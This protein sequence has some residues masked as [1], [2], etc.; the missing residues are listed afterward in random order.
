VQKDTTAFHHH[1]DTITKLS[2]RILECQRAYYRGSPLISDVEYDALE[3][4][5]QQL[6]PK[7][8]I[9]WKVGHKG[10]VDEGKKV[11]HEPPMLSLAKTY[12]LEELK[13]WAKGELLTGTL[14]VD[15]VSLSLVYENGLLVLAKTRGN[16]E[17]GEDV[18]K[19]IEWVP[20][21]LR[22]LVSI[23]PGGVIPQKA[24][25]RG[26]LYC[27][28]A[29]FS[30]LLI[31]ME[32]LALDKPTSP[33]NIVAGILGRKHHD[34]LARYFGFF[35]FDLLV[36]FQEIPFKSEVEKY[37]WLEDHRFKLPFYKA[38]KTEAQIASFL[39]ETK[40][41][42]EEGELGI[43]GAVFT[44]D[45]LSKHEELGKTSHHPRYKLSYKWQGETKESQIKDI[46]WA[47]SRLGIVTPVAIVDP[48][49]LSSAS[50]TNVTLHNAAYVKQ[51]NLKTGDVIK[52]VRSGEVIPKFLEVVEAASGEAL[53]PE[54]CP[55]CGE[56]LYYDQVR[57]LCS[58]KKS[59]PAQQFGSILNWI[60]CAEIDDLSEKRVRSMVEL[61][62][63][64]HPSDLYRLSL[65]DLLKLP[66]TK[67]KMAQKL[68]TNI[69]K[70]KMLPLTQFLNGLGV[71]G[72]GRALWEEV[73]QVFPSLE[74]ILQ[75]KLEDIAAISGFGTLRATV[76][77]E[78]LQEK[79]P[80]IQKLLEVGV[81]PFIRVKPVQQGS[82]PLAGKLFV[83]TGSLSRPRQEVVDA[84]VLAG[85]K[86]TESVSKK[87]TALITEALDSG[88]SKAKKAQ[89]LTIPIWSEKELWDKTKG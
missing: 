26:E 74:K 87:V 3:K 44:Y 82:L 5:L 52:I 36:S 9:L 24:E 35:A 20:D 47:T 34:A 57:L 79:T 43:D 1:K 75:A 6:D 32:A 54:N 89:E 15:G 19:K 48:V 68:L 50:I 77:V 51:F 21:C 86:V 66:L 31:E 63:I 70:S 27:D 4:Q 78:A 60:R 23:K 71:P 2:E 46:R 28:D 18:T 84:I 42:M 22:K 41:F 10:S 53:L 38:L 55:S 49:Y 25:I 16:G 83:I 33:R 30:K 59:C 72:M 8:P 62:L 67:E 73:L 80:D 69:A 85:G 58:Q 37:H 13:T 11:A 81:E 64:S 39:E 61:G 14:K 40:Y 65:E 17:W 76:V 88:S 12:D 45:D 56:V 29:Q 7:H